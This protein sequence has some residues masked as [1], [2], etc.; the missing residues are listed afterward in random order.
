MRE[1]LG[2]RG[3]WFAGEH[4]APFVALGTVTGAW[5]SGEAVA[6]R[7][8]AAYGGLAPGGDAEGSLLGGKGLDGVESPKEVN[9][10]TFG[11][12]GLLGSESANIGV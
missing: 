1:G 3:L 11:D 7:I 5:W 4:V 6:G 8:V 9:F 10:R 12:D 2:E